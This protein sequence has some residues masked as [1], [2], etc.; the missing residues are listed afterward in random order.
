MFAIGNDDIT[1]CLVKSNILFI[2][3]PREPTD[4]RE[5][6]IIEK[7]N[8]K[9][10]LLEWTWADLARAMKI[11]EQR[12][13]NRKKRGVP[14]GQIK[15][16]AATIGMQRHELEGDGSTQLRE[17]TAEQIEVLAIWDLL[18]T[19]QREEVKQWAEHIRT[20]LREKSEGQPRVVSASDRR[21]ARTVY[22]GY[23]DRR[24]KKE[25]S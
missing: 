22:F 4:N 23:E 10:E 2:P 14:A 13:N 11:T 24:D 25:N 1:E 7:I 20:V 9:L 6:D 18:L 19:S 3:Q 5:M 12:V 15:H 21:K 8:A 16:V 17:L